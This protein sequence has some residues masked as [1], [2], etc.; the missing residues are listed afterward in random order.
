MPL[1][2]ATRPAN[3]VADEEAP[4]DML[5]ERPGELG[6]ALAIV[7]LEREVVVAEVRHGARG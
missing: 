1:Q 6:E 4:A 7:G 3:V 5:V 2:D